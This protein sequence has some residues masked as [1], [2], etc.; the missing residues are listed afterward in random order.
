MYKHIL[1][2]GVDIN[3]KGMAL[4]CDGIRYT[5]SEVQAI[6]TQYANELMEFGVKSG[7]KVAICVG[8]PLE[9]IIS[10]FSVGYI[11]AIP[12]P[13]YSKT[14]Y[15]KMES[16]I[17]RYDVNYVIKDING[18]ILN[19]KRYVFHDVLELYVYNQTIDK[20]IN[21]AKLVLFTSG[22]TN[23]PKAIMLS[24]KNITSN[25]LAIGKYLKLI[26]DDNILL[27]KD[28][29]HS[30]SIIGELFVGI[31]NGCTIVLTQKLPL[32]TIILKIME[33]E[34]ISVFFSVPTLLKN[35]ISFNKISKFDLSKLRIINFYG[36][37]MNQDDIKCL[38]KIF[39]DANIIYSYGQTEASPRITYIEREDIVK[40]PGSCGRAIEEVDICIMDENGN[41][42]EYGSQGEITITGPNVML[43][44]YRD[45]ER[46]KQVIRN[47]RLFT[48]D[49][50][51]LNKEGYLYIMG[52]KD[53]MVISAGKNIY[54]E[55]IES[56][57]LTYE[58][59]AEALVVAEMKRDSTCLLNAYVVIEESKILDKNNLFIYL[60]DRLENYKIP[61][62]V[63]EV[64]KLEK[65]AS[66]K[67]M[68]K[69]F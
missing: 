44:Y 15:E 41:K 62:E 63:I 26:C 32:T 67:I 59:I 61:K 6:I 9:F 19:S 52:R 43:G 51:I 58:C 60:R 2:R 11:G 34:K 30:S 68:R 5:Y 29:S 37:A 7:S 20:Y 54:P 12:M 8:T 56:V 21:G 35:I 50:G 28:L 42:V 53:N 13:M 31:Y 38:M 25:I 3:P 45:R 69:Q 57:L 22:T 27:I 47:D 10:L 65:T 23:E 66:G 24:E 48:G 55:E 39:E 46:T 33:E 18:E 4:V 14:G 64:E 40:Y 36:A 16:I 49:I 1:K 17:S